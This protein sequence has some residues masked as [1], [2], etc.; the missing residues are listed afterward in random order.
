MNSPTRINAR[1]FFI[2]QKNIPNMST[3]PPPV[4]VLCQMLLFCLFWTS[5]GS[6][7]TDK[8][9]DRMSR[10]PIFYG[11]R[12]EA[13]L[14]DDLLQQP[15]W[16]EKLGSSNIGAALNPM[17]DQDD[18][19]NDIQNVGRLVMKGYLISEN[20]QSRILNFD[21]NFVSKTRTQHELPGKS[22]NVKSDFNLLSRMPGYF[23]ERSSS[24]SDN[25]DELKSFDEY[26]I[27]KPLLI[28]PP[29]SFFDGSSVKTTIPNL[30]GFNHQYAMKR[31]S[32]N[33]QQVLFNKLA[34][35]YT[36]SE[37]AVGSTNTHKRYFNTQSDNL[38]PKLCA[39]VTR[40]S[41]S[42][43]TK[44]CYIGSTIFN[45]PEA[46][47]T[48]QEEITEKQTNNF[49]ENGPDIKTFIID[50]RG[51]EKRGNS[52]GT[53]S[54]DTDLQRSDYANVNSNKRRYMS[55]L[56]RMPQFFGKRN[57]GIFPQIYQKEMGA[58][59]NSIELQNYKL[60]SEPVE[61]AMQSGG[62]EDLNSSELPFQSTERHH[63][64]FGLDRNFAVWPESQVRNIL[65][66][67]I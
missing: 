21:N 16:S 19:Q 53:D 36:D 5:T 38:I 2:F 29:M 28:P 31:N 46:S 41:S 32:L 61:Q 17:A 51:Y 1:L 54:S 8:R 50:S 30:A 24:G 7:T 56:D 26:Q 43:R 12:S 37:S 18:E 47:S 57:A 27:R 55:A 63:T 67:R 13:A 14:A 45:L 25:F 64:K 6:V 40:L 60:G 4:F 58:N 42:A 23:G 39:I 3:T 44:N 20:D 22:D 9:S 15:P 33:L 65:R 48:E 59:P 35:S 10:M 34:Q 49:D 66:P 11:K 52:K 62:L